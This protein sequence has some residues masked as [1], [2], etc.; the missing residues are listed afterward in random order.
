MV[1]VSIILP[2]YNEYRNLKNNFPK[3][4][5]AAKKLESFEIIIAEDGS[6][7]GSIVLC[8]EFA[9]LPG[10]RVMHREQ[11]SGKGAAIKRSVRAA[12]GKVIGYMDI[13]LAVPV[14][15]TKK[16]IYEVEKGNKIVIGSRYVAGS[17]TRRNLTRHFLSFGYNGL[18]FILFG[19]R[20]K[21][22]QCGFKFMEGSYAKRLTGKVRDNYWFFDAEMLIRAE[23][24][25]VAPYELPVE[26]NE[27]RETKLRPKD[28]ALFM[29]SMLKFRFSP[30]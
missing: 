20:V 14:S 6:T 17:E 25:G 1:R 23:R 2:V 12:K 19:S 26:W 21:D 8:R 22:H 10:V 24:D 9:K 3:I 15:Y 16:A 11:K 28:V 18:I 7:D 4:Y 13:D 30:G 5:S 27:Q 29:V